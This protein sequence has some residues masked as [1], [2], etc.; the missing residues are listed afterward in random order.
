MIEKL[1]NFDSAE[2]LESDEAIS[3][4]M[5]DAFLTN[6]AGYIAHAFE[7]AMRAKKQKDVP[8]NVVFAEDL[9]EQM[10]AEREE[11]TLKTALTLARLIGIQI[12]VQ[13]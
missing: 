7:V 8:N 1:T 6:D 12:T 10:L 11:L 3:I 9:I 13:N 2:Y 5:A 4:F